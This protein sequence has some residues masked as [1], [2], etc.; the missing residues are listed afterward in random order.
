MN[1]FS[2][3][4]PQALTSRPQPDLDT[5]LRSDLP[6]AGANGSV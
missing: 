4:I 6:L 3:P 5:N 1:R 2:F